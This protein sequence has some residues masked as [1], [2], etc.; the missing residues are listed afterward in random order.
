[1]I[2]HMTIIQPANWAQAMPCKLKKQC[3]SW[4]CGSS[5]RISVFEF[6]SR[7]PF[8][9]P[10]AADWRGR[11]AAARHSDAAAARRAAVRRSPGATGTV[12]LPRTGVDTKCLLR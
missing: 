8:L 2:L 6:F 10:L 4:E 3:V 1:M 7:L 9:A 11:P 12:A 5:R